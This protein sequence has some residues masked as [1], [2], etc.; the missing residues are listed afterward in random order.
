MGPPNFLGHIPKY[1]RE[2]IDLALAEDDRETLLFAGISAAHHDPD[3]KYA[4]NLCIRLYEHPNK[5]VR[6]NA[7]LGL[8]T[9]AKKQGSLDLIT[10]EPILLRALRD[11]EG[12]VRMRAED[13][14]KEINAALN[15]DISKEKS[16][17][18]DPE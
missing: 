3:W 10:T 4:Q 9:I 15:W 8:A 13:T 11:P 17:F 5:T 14:I 18:Q 12:E 1:R 2:E 6:G 16:Q 7:I